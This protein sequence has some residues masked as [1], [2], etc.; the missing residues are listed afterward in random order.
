MINYNKQNFGKLAI[1]FGFIF[2]LVSSVYYF[3]HPA[4]SKL[5]GGDIIL[6]ILQ[7]LKIAGLIVLMKWI[8]YKFLLEEP[9]TKKSR[10]IGLGTLIAL[11]SSILYSSV[12]YM[13]MTLISPEVLEVTKDEILREVFNSP[14]ADKKVEM[15]EAEA[16]V[17]MIPIYTFLLN[18]IYCFIY[19]TVLSIFLAYRIKSEAEQAEVY[20]PIDEQ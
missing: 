6:M 16:F 4:A 17:S 5:P 1:T 11:V 14:G 8:M 3:I 18:M 12:I 9:E 20:T 10:L 15:Q 2:A 19:G 7:I 13:D